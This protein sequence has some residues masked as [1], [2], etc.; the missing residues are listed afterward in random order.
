M[1]TQETQY[2]IGDLVKLTSDGDRGI[3]VKAHRSLRRRRRW[4]WQIY[5]F[6]HRDDNDYYHSSQ[7]ILLSESN[8]NE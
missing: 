4:C 2:S 6:R 1:S 3:V 7:L 8:S 5:W